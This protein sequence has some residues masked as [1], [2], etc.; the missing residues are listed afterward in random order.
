ME[1]K[2]RIQGKMTA[3]PSII[4]TK[5]LAPGPPNPNN[6]IETDN[7]KIIGFIQFN[8]VLSLAM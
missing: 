1:H 5:I 7:N 3:I 2:Q 8:N 6:E 4:K